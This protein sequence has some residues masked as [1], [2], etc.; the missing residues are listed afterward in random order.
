MQNPPPQTR[1]C[2][3]FLRREWGGWVIGYGVVVVEMGVEGGRGRR[4]RRALKVY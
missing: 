1:F 3:T 2:R 4:R